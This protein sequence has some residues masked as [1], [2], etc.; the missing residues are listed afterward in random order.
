[1][2]VTIATL[3][4]IAAMVAAATFYVRAHVRKT[5]AA[6]KERSAALAAQLLAEVE[7]E[8]ERRGG[9]VHSGV[10]EVVP[11]VEQAHVEQAHVEQVLA[12]PAVPGEG[13]AASSR[14]L[15]DDDGL[16]SFYVTPMTPLPRIE[17][18]D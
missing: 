7:A 9:A 1:M 10:D 6:D 16:E 8:R 12:V 11:V 18:V 4:A 3:L 2:I 15:L 17:A 13:E 5:M 14:A